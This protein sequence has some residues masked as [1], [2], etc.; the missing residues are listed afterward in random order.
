MCKESMAA[1]TCPRCGQHMYYAEQHLAVCTA[2]VPVKKAK[3][4]K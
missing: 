4:K 1:G 3:V 2:P